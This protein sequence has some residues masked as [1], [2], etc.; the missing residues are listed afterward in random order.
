MCKQQW[1]KGQ[2]QAYTHACS[3]FF[4]VF[5]REWESVCTALFYTSCSL[6]YILALKF[7]IRIYVCMCKCTHV[8]V[9]SCNFTPSNL[10][11]FVLVLPKPLF[12]NQ[13]FIHLQFSLILPFALRSPQP[14]LSVAAIYSRAIAQITN[15]CG[16]R[17]RIVGDTKQSHTHTCI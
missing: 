5:R 3:F 8:F 11:Y 9:I 16:F 7:I 10:I 6:L 1:V 2:L 12:P 15:N 13:L 17:V 4:Q 14:L